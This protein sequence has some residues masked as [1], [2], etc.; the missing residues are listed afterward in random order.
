MAYPKCEGPIVIP[1]AWSVK[2][3]EP[4]GAVQT[5]TIPAGTYYLS[6]T[7]GANSSL[8]TTLKT[9]LDAN[10]TLA[11]TYTVSV[12]DNSNSSTGKVTIS[13]TGAASFSI[14]EWTS[15]DLE[16]VL[17]FTTTTSGA[18]TYTGANQATYLWLPSVPRARILAPEPTTTTYQ[19]GLRR[20]DLTRAPSPDG[21][22]VRMVYN[23]TYH[24]SFEF[25]FLTANKVF[26]SQESVVN[27]SFEKFYDDVIGSGLQFRYHRDRSDDS[28]SWTQVIEDA[29]EFRAE[30]MAGSGDRGWRQGASSLWGIRY[31]MTQAV[32]E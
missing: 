2:F 30:P 1:T 27:E 17:G 10:V 25:D 7:N 22:S 23:T 8:T 15:T 6:T 9:L 3:Q 32:G 28:V 29:E 4:P 12:D 20:V 31:R 5:I 26:Q 11:G 19:L 14:T 21:R 18:L 13:A 24:D 16:V